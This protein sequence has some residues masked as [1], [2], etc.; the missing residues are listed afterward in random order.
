MAHNHYS[1]LTNDEFVAIYTGG[2]YN[3]IQTNPKYLIGHESLANS[4]DWRSE[5]KVSKV[6][7]QG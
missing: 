4:K 2:N 6:K 7:N 3:P 5:G 1:D